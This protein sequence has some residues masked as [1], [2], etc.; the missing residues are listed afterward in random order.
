M[1]E[2][3]DIQKGSG[4]VRIENDPARRG[5]SFNARSERIKASDIAAQLFPAEY[6][7]GQSH[8]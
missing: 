1:A 5:T 2:L 7:A 6:A 4:A 8:V 3:S